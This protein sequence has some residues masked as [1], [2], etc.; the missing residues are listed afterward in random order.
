MLASNQRINLAVA[1]L[2]IQVDGVL[3]QRIRCSGLRVFLLAVEAGIRLL[4]IRYPGNTVR[5]IVDDFETGNILF[6]QEIDRLGFLLAENGHQHVSTVDL[7]FSGRLYVENRTLQDALEAQ[8][9][10]GLT[11]LGHRHQGRGF[12][13]KSG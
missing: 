7:T 2:L 8:R 3:L 6:L 13:Q 11:F 1:G 10:L 12:I 5:N 9:R 4:V